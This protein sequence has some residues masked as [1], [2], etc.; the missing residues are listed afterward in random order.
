MNT[1]ANTSSIPTPIPSIK[2]VFSKPRRALAF[3]LGSGLAP[4]APGTVG[5]LWAWAAF[6]MG[7]YFMKQANPAEAFVRFSQS[8]QQARNVT[9]N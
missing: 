3:G 1:P 9:E 8:L 4:Y 2:W 5:T 6:L 7:E